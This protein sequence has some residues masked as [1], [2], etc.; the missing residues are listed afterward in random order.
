MN[1]R[2]RDAIKKHTASEIPIQSNCRGNNE[3]AVSEKELIVASD[4][5]KSGIRAETIHQSIFLK[6]PDFI[7]KIIL[8]VLFR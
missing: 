4:K 1:E 6:N 8:G 5:P 2:S 7:W 3:P